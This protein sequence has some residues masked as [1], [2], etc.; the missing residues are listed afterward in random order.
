MSRNK[1]AKAVDANQAQIVK[2]LRQMG[3]LV[4]C[5]HAAAGGFPDLVVGWRGR[6]HQVEVKCGSDLTP[7]QVRYHAKW[8]GYVTIIENVEQAIALVSKIKGER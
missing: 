2:A 5:T 6:T 1:Y 4:E 3:M 7:A 8:A